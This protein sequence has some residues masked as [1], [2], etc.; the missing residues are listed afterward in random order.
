[1]KKIVPCFYTVVRKVLALEAR[2][3]S[4]CKYESVDNNTKIKS[5]INSLKSPKLLNI[6]AYKHVWVDR[7]VL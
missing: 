3:F 5:A 6:S 4:T 2:H 7:V 1:M